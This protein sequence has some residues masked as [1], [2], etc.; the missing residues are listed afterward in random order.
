VE[1]RKRTI[2]IKY[3]FDINYNQ[4]P[5][6]RN[7]LSKLIVLA[8]I[9]MMAV[10]CQTEELVL[11]TQRQKEISSKK[12][13]YEEML[14]ITGR[15]E[16]LE[17]FIKNGKSNYQQKLVYDEK[18][19]F[20]IDTDHIVMMQ[21]GE[22]INFTIPIYRDV[23]SD[24]VENLVLTSLGTGKYSIMLFK[25]SLS[26]DER[27]QAAE[28]EPIANLGD[29][30]EID[31][32]GDEN[33]LGMA[34]G[35]YIGA[36]LLATDGNCYRI[37]RVYPI[38]DVSEWTYDG[39]RINCPEELPDQ[40]FTDG[41][42]GSGG[43]IVVWYPIPVSVGDNGGSTGPTGPGGTTP[44]GTNPT[45]PEE[46]IEPGVIITEPVIINMGYYRFIRNLVQSPDPAENAKAEWIDDNPDVKEGLQKWFDEDNWMTYPQK[47]DFSRWVIDYLIN[48]PDISW[49]EIENWF[50]D[51][52]EG[53]DGEYDE[54]FWEDPEL[55]FQDKDLPTL[56]DF[57]NAFP[58]IDNGDTVQN[59][60]SSEVY[61]LVGGSLLTNHESGNP[62]YQ[63][64][65]A[66]RGSRAL[67][68]AG[69][70][71]PV[72]HQDGQQKT[73]KGSDNKNYILA[74]KAFNIYMRKTFG[75]PTH[76]LTSEDIGGD[77]SKIADFLKGKTGIYTII[78]TAP[79]TAGYGGHVDI[80]IDGKCLGGANTNPNG[81][82]AYIE[83]W[84]L[85]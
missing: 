7:N 9:C 36:I 15:Q 8:I 70:P 49:D 31:L 54:E 25:Y 4:K 51:K 53:K 62:N 65:C 44:G 32:M 78:N 58:K 34:A 76:R 82:V 13:S 61:E 43:G 80:I 12:I 56:I 60:P 69:V 38:G 35:G 30:T 71:I 37:T 81:G 45:S 48:N 47:V 11:D 64:A 83:I 10:C 73:E 79:G 40:S 55:D 41:E 39:V 72:V 27:K 26:P 66:I 63:N 52:S 33:I 22:K 3:I 75:P 17:R 21:K 14:R 74:A 28:G 16:K 46:P 20:W 77:P 29:K 19:G 5:F 85:N 24:K 68:Y 42:G 18:N 57:F 23:E 1:S 59:L 84:E 2:L 50:F 67:N 6:M